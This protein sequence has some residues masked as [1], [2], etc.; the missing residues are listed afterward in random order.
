VLVIGEMIGKEVVTGGI[1]RVR[2]E[3]FEVIPTGGTIIIPGGAPI[4]GTIIPGG[5]PI[6]GTIIPGGA[7]IRGTIII[8]GG[9]PIGGTIIPGGNIPILQIL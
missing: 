1:G 5:A 6:G 4:G 7:P 8:P 2:G 3:K 9:A